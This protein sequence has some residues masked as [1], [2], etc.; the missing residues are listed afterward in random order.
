MK[1]G[2]EDVKLKMCHKL[3]GW[4]T[5]KLP[6]AGKIV[7]IGSNFIGIRQYSMNWF[8]ILKYICKNIDGFYWRFFWKGN[9]DNKNNQH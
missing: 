8:K 6:A 3:A 4:E 9:C 2:F 7:L 5:R 1:E